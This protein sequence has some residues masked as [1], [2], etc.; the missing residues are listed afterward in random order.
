MSIDRTDSAG[1]VL[2]GGGTVDSSDESGE[3]ASNITNR[4]D[5]VAAFGDSWT[6]R[7]DSQLLKQ[8]YGI[9]LNPTDNSADFG[10]SPS[11]GALK[12][13]TARDYYYV[14]GDFLIS[15]PW[16]VSAGESYVIFI[17]GNMTLD[18]PA[19]VEQLVQVEDG[20]FLAFIVS[21]TIT[22]TEDVGNEAD[23]TSLNTNVEGIYIAD[24]LLTIGSK[25]MA[26]GGDERFVGAGTFVGWGGVNLLRD[27]S[28]GGL[29]KAE[30][31]DKPIESFI[32][33][34]DF[35]SNAPEKM[36][37]AQMIWQEVN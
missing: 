36:T 4:A 1:F 28:D 19:A 26:A 23:L 31:N 3:Q 5:Q 10:G 25:G 35:M 33:R 29:R 24:G 9:G 27:F 16:T 32:F 17:D 11:T 2:T 7:E 30:N 15:S 21:G 20:G 8:R 37:Q 13:S 14:P 22:I 34:P 18:D 12:P 6:L